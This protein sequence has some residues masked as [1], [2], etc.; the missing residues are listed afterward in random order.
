A[1]DALDLRLAT[2]LSLGADFAGHTGDFG[3]ERAELID[4]RV[5]GVLQLQNFAFDVDGDLLGQVAACDRLG[6]VGDIAHL[7]G[8]AAGHE[9][10]AVGEVFPGAGH[11]LHVGLPA[12]AALGADFARH[13]GDFGG[14][15]SQLIDHRVDGVFQLQDFAAHVHGDLFR[16]V[17]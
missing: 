17:T 2:Q 10:D 5:D 9:V 6:A 12:Q 14:K 8:E 16:K 15:R 13:A 11:A 3:G 7:A 1:R 4:H